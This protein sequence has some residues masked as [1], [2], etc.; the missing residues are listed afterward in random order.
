MHFLPPYCPDDNL[1]EQVW[2]DLH[3]NVTRNYQCPTFV[4]LAQN[5]VGFL[6]SYEVGKI[7]KSCS[8]ISA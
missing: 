2:L 8:E 6:D 7:E 5:V 3:D 1:I 4:E